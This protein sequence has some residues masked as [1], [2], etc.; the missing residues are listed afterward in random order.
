MSFLEGTPSPSH[1]NSI[2][3]MSHPGGTTVPGEGYSTSPSQVRMEYLPGQ[4]GIATLPHPPSQD[5]GTPWPGQDGASPLA[6]MGYPPP[7]PPPGTGYTWTGHAA[8]GAPVAVS[9]RRTFL[10]LFTKTQESF[11][12]RPNIIVLNSSVDGVPLQWKCGR[13]KMSPTPISKCQCQFFRWQWRSALTVV[14]IEFSPWKLYVYC[15]GCGWRRAADPEDA[16]VE[17]SVPLH[18]GKTD[19]QT[20]HQRS[21]EA[22]ELGVYPMSLESRKEL[23][24]AH[25]ATHA[26]RVF[27]L[28][29]TEGTF[30]V[31]F[32]QN[33][34]LSNCS[35]S[36]QCKLLQTGAV[37]TQR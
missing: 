15:P 18:C 30:T 22:D 35:K 19:R 27:T 4:D 21:R 3:S 34:C 8:S 23:S 26:Y 17:S 28:V 25:L 37:Y 32:R 31:S 6:R 13:F 2:G 10:S 5:W 29:N 33:H 1:N 12:F 11:R 36:F 24:F 9:R 14:W 7:P 16:V 20:D